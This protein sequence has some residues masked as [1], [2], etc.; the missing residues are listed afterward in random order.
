MISYP[1]MNDHEPQTVDG[2]LWST[3]NGLMQV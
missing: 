2:G 1:K 3:V